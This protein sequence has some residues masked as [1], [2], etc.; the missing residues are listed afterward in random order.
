MA[1]SPVIYAR[2]HQERRLDR[3]FYRVQIQPIMQNAHREGRIGSVGARRNQRLLGRPAGKP[4]GDTFV[5]RPGLIVVAAP[6]YQAK[7]PPIALEQLE[8]GLVS[9]QHVRVFRQQQQALLPRRVRIMIARHQVNMNARAAELAHSLEKVQVVTI[10]R[11]CRIEDIACNGHEVDL[12]LKR[13]VNNA[14]E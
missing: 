6:R 14:V 12:T 13:H 11:A 3:S 9:R 4:L 10:R 2:L 5:S 8:A 1:A 7:R